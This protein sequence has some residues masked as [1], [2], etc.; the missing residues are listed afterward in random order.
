MAYS[1]DPIAAYVG[2]LRLKEVERELWSHYVVPLGK[3][4]DKCNDLINAY[5]E[6]KQNGWSFDMPDM[7][8]GRKQ[9]E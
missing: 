2:I 8:R 3:I 4:A 1:R 5:H 9:I 7:P 6:D